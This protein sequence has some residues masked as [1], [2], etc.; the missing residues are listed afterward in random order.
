MLDVNN[1]VATRAPWRFA[2][3][4]ET[5]KYKNMIKRDT[6]MKKIASR[7]VPLEDFFCS[8]SFGIGTFVAGV[9][10]VMPLGGLISAKSQ[11]RQDVID[12]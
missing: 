1:Q 6:F 2:Y 11:T 4:T 9:S 5:K 10:I 12:C 3:E 7:D 8:S